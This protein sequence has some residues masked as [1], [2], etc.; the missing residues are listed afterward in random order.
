MSEMISVATGFQYSVNIEYD[1]ND[2]SKIENFIPTTAALSLLEE[3]LLSVN[4]NSPDRA[5]VLIGAYGRGK[6]HIVL[7][8]L[9]ILMRKPLCKNILSKL[10]SNS[11]LYR[12]IDSYYEGS[13]KILPVVIT[14]SRTSLT[15]SFLLALRRTLKNNNLSN[16]MPNTNYKAAIY[17]IERWRSQF[18]KTLAQLQNKIDEPLEQFIDRLENFD[19]DA[20]RAFEKIYP[21]LTAGSEF[22]PFLNFDVVELY[23][24]V[25][26][27]LKREGYSGIY[28][29]YDEFSKYL[30]ANIEKA[31][32]SDTKMLQ[33][34]AEKCTRSSELQMHLMLI[35]HKE[36]ANYINKL[37][38]QK[39]DGWRGI[40][41]RFKHVHLNDNFTQV[42]EIISN[43]IERREPQWKNFRTEFDRAFDELIKRYATHKIFSDSKAE[44]KKIV[45]CCYPLHPVSTFILP[46]L[47]NK[48]AQN[49][50]TLFTF[51][52]SEGI[53]TL[54]TFLH[55]FDDKT[56]WLITPDQIYDYFEPL[57]RKE[58]YSSE[59]HQIYLLASNILQSLTP[60]SLGSKMIKTLALIYMLDQFERLQPTRDELI[61]IYSTEYA[62]V[63]IE[64][65]LDELIDGDFVLY[66]KRSNHFLKLKQKSS[67]D[68]R[69]QIKDQIERQ[70]LDIRATLNEANFDAFVYPHRY[71]DAH[72]MVRYFPFRFIDS[73]EIDSSTDWDVK[74]ETLDGDGIIY[75]ILPN[76]E[77]DIDK[78]IK[79]LELTSRE[80]ARYI[81]VIPKHYRDII[82]IV[83]EYQAVDTLKNKAANDPILFDEYE[84]IHDDLNEMLKTFIGIYTRPEDH[85]AVYIHSGARISINR[86][87]DLTEL[88]STICDEVYFKTPIINNEAL[89]RNEITSIAAN[90]RHKLIGALLRTELEPDLGFKSTT[91]EASI[92]RGTLINTDV[93]INTEDSARIN[94]KPR[95]ENM[96]FVMSTIEQFIQTAVRKSFDE[97]YQRLIS[98]KYGIGLRRGLIPLY[99][100]TV[101]REHRTYVVI[102]CKD[103]QVALNVDTVTRLDERPY[104]FSIEYLDWY[105]ERQQYID[106]LA[107]IFSDHMTCI[108]RSNGS[109]DRIAN[110]MYRW[111][112]SLPKY[113]REERSNSDGAKLL[114]LLR[115]NVG[116]AELL[117][118]K[119]PTLIGNDTD[120]VRRIKSYYDSF[121]SVVTHELINEIKLIFAIDSRN[122]DLMSLTSALRDWL[123]ILDENVFE[124][125]F[126]DGTDKFLST[127]RDMTNNEEEFI[128][129]TARLATGLRLEDWND[130]TRQ[131]FI[132]MIKQYKRTAEEFGSKFSPS[133]DTSEYN[134]ITFSDGSVQRFERTEITPRGQLLFNQ[135]TDALSSMGQ[136]ISVREKR[137]VL[138]EA[139]KT[140]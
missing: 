129:R 27:S 56:F 75:G 35:S 66:L 50:R 135:I 51:L 88:L 118:K 19:V 121:L 60:D 9:S 113:A 100:T 79:L 30:E 103:E 73:A 40:S 23:E 114:K 2:D 63:E 37:P 68:I 25:V 1:W 39:L 101:L 107:E 58:V 109:Y 43:V 54:P 31:S 85:A 64:R 115:Q 119:L 134:Q 111:F 77:A 11:K 128:T 127:I 80:H 36:I 110:A 52:A 90:S 92:M 38:K 45:E 140:I 72:E 65:A 29:V 22:N 120:I 112:M 132:E 78:L 15:Q 96:Q 117:F 26:E 122:I 124:Q 94:L 17:T 108:E 74:S 53:S 76:D 32:V 16:I 99:I 33:D 10:E 18:P 131:A 104:E 5:R 97:L 62:G 125:L 138:L 70:T 136:S 61:G 47:S 20:Y 105:D 139:F 89:N 28:V 82:E 95:S 84:I 102:K 7:I 137:Q 4:I 133:D 24:N 55:A 87:A 48:V 123:E 57:L 71:N 12:L 41:E 91:Q 106:G 13:T 8:I 44:L 3:I 67:T 69:Q 14:G 59:V 81:F 46:R 98:P 49:E 126:N 21:Q 86:R 116:S 93:L 83:A 130:T 6:S 42:Y 34:F